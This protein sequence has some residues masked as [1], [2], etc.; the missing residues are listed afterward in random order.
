MDQKDLRRGNVPEIT[1]LERRSQS[2][3]EL[4]SSDVMNILRKRAALAG[5]KSRF[6][7]QWS[8]DAAGAGKVVKSNR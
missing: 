3:A 7:A 4:S 5:K 8:D 1:I 6:E 2:R